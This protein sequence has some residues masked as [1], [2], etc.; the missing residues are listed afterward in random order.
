MKKNIISLLTILPVLCA[1]LAA[2][3]CRKDGT[4]SGNTG[5]TSNDT[6]NVTGDFAPS[7]IGGKTF[8]GHIGGT[9]TTWQIVFTGSGS[10]GT[11]TYAENGRHLEDGSYTYTKTSENTATLVLS[12]GS[13]IQFT[14]TGPNAGTYFIPKSSENGTFTNT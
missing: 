12:D 4:A 7:G 10:S 5:G 2:A 11:Y 3:G 6:N 14:W 13:T 9:A 1:V 8:N